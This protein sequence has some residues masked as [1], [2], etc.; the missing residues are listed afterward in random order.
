MK[1][2]TP[3]TKCHRCPFFN[4]IGLDAD[5][6]G[7]IVFIKGTCMFYGDREIEQDTPIKPVWCRVNKVTAEEEA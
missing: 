7:A 1:R 4:L 2:S 5:S 3:I 6:S